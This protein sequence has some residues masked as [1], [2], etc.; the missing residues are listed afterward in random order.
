MK[1]EKFFYNPN[2]KVWECIE[3]GY[4]DH[5]SFFRIIK[6]EQL[7]TCLFTMGL[8]ICPKCDARIMK[9]IDSRILEDGSSVSSYVVA[10]PE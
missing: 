6:G 1:N 3:C 10:T 9:K 4:K 2:E 5:Q 8:I 7:S